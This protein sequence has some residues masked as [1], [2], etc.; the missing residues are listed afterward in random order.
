MKHLHFLPLWLLVSVLLILSLAGCG[1][2]PETVHEHRYGEWYVVTPA[3]HEESGIE[4]RNC[5]GCER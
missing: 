5:T 1:E 3:T 2:T 4:A